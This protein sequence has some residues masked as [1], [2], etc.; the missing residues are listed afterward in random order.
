[1]DQ[2]PPDSM[3]ELQVG[4][5]TGNY[6]REASKWANFIAIVVFVAGGLLTILLAIGVTFLFSD[7]S[8]SGLSGSEING[9]G[10]FV[11]LIGILAI[12]V[13]MF[14]A[15]LLLRFALRM[16]R[17]LDNQDQQIFNSSLRA[18]KNHFMIMGIIA[19]LGFIYSLFLFG[20]SIYTTYVSQS[21][22]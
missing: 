6:F 1:M 19:I 5:S 12:L 15:F 11:V 18:F 21:M 7:I 16:R 8:N 2:H 17:A 4:Y 14:A 20:F 13:Y 10:G 22:F 3:F 9:I